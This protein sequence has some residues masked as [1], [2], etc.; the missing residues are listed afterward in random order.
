MNSNE[1]CRWL[2]GF[3]EMAD[4]KTLN[5]KQL[6]VIREHLQLVFTKV[7]G[8]GK[9]IVKG[10]EGTLEGIWR[11]AFGGEDPRNTRLC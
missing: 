7:T 4:P 10:L 5:E 6:Q 2:Q 1:F 3:F 11:E 8:S 9:G